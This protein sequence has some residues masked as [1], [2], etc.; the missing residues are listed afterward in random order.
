MTGGCVDCSDNQ[1]DE[2]CGEL[3]EESYHCMNGRDQLGERDDDT[4]VCSAVKN[5]FTV[6]NYGGV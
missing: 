5:A 3:Y 6:I 2:A 4:S 1:G